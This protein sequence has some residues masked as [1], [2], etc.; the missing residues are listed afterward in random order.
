M[1]CEDAMRS[2]DVT[3]MSFASIACS[4]EDTGGSAI[5]TLCNSFLP[6]S[7]M[8]LALVSLEA[9]SSPLASLWN[10]L[11]M[12]RALATMALAFPCSLAILEA[13]SKSRPTR[14]LERSILD[15]WRAFASAW[16]S[17]T[18]SRDGLS[19]S[20]AIV[21]RKR[22]HCFGSRQCTPRPCMLSLDCTARHWIARQRALVRML[23]A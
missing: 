20:L 22:L 14:S 2:S 10:T 5:P 4:I 15:C 9:P 6:K 3:N 1:R 17:R 7:C 23:R 11:A 16:S 18:R 13:V 8:V 19:I 12:P 21:R